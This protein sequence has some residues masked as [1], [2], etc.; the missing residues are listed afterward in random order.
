MSQGKAGTEADG[1][2]VKEGYS[3]VNFGDT[4]VI[5]T[6]SQKGKLERAGIKIAYRIALE[7]EE[8]AA[9]IKWCD[10]HPI[11]KHIYAIPNGSHKSPATAMKFKR[12]GLRP[13]VPDLCLPVPR[14]AFHG[15]YFEMKRTKGGVISDKQADWMGFLAQQGYYC[16]VCKG[17]DE[18]IQAIKDYLTGV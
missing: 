18:A 12:E 8:Q 9:V 16:K 13:G 10:L 11:A 7:S 6:R 4:T 2:T 3:V 15:A 17:A 1:Q 14:G 5:F